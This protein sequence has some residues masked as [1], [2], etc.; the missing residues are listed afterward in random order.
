MLRNQRRLILLISILLL[1]GCSAADL[2]ATTPPIALWARDC[3]PPCWLGIEPGIT[4]ID[5]AEAILR[6]HPDAAQNVTV[7]D[8]PFQ[9]GATDVIEWTFAVEGQEWIGAI[10]YTGSTEQVVP[11]FHF[12]TPDVCLG[13]VIAAYGDPEWLAKPIYDFSAQALVVW[14]RLGFLYWSD[15]LPDP[16][17]G[18]TADTCGGVINHFPYGTALSQLPGLELLQFTDSSFTPWVG[19]GEY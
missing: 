18:V 2:P 3:L 6:D 5:G 17:A 12:E 16:A 13:A 1:A 10:P 8:A 15:N 19:Y 4:T 9:L 7:P 11:S 14:P